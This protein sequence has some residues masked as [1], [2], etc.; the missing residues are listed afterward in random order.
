[1][2]EDQENDDQRLIHINDK[3]IDAI[4]IIHQ[5][6]ISRYETD[7]PLYICNISDIIRKHQAWKRCMPRVQPF[8]GEILFSVIFEFEFKCSFG[9]IAVKCND[10]PIVIKTLASLGTGFDC[11]S[12]GEIEKIMIFDVTPESIIYANPN[13][14]V[15]HLKYASRVEVDLMTVDNEFEL[16]KIYTYYPQAR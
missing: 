8:Y 12:K 15:S 2:K 4:D 9:C 6:A 16:Q 5:K 11:A 1:M 3:P 10:D 13:K 14:P 7:E